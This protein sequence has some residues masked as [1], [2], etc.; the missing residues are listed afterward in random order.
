MGANL[1]KPASHSLL[2]SVA[3]HNLGA[4]ATVRIPAG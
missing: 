1:S 2:E 3:S 4:I